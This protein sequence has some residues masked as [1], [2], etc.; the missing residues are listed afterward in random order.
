MV[1]YQLALK[2]LSLSGY[3]VVRFI[4]L[5]GI[6]DGSQEI[7]SSISQQK[8]RHE[9]NTSKNALEALYKGDIQSFKDELKKTEA[10]CIQAT[11][12]LTAIAAEYPNRALLLPV[13][14]VLGSIFAV[15]GETTLLTK[16]ADGL[17]VYQPTQ[18]FILAATVVIAAS[19]IVEIY[20]RLIFERTGSPN[21]SSKQTKYLG[22]AANAFL[23]LDIAFLVFFGWLRSLEILK[24]NSEEWGQ[25]F[26]DNPFVTTGCC[27]LITIILPVF[28]GCAFGS[29][30]ERLNHFFRSWK[31]ERKVTRLT[32][33]IDQLNHQTLAFEKESEH[34]QAIVEEHTLKHIQN[35]NNW[36]QRGEVL[37]DLNPYFWLKL[38]KCFAVCLL[39][40][41]A[42][43][44]SDPVI[45]SYLV[46]D[47]LR[48]L[49]YAGLTIGLTALFVYFELDPMA[50][51]N[52]SLK[53]HY[54]NQKSL[55]S[56]V[57]K[58]EPFTIFNER[59]NFNVY[60]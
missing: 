14:G 42:F 12:E 38:F 28:V 6:W 4:W 51:K 20:R 8:I 27:I 29:S 46:S 49:V 56:R 37:F 16:L 47:G 48:Y 26:Q 31:A 19:G 35:Y 17:G 1:K 7:D 53:N 22:L 40:L 54:Q 11:Q 36:Y 10:S 23:A 45:A 39:I 33:Q 9:F 3:S 52:I 21:S 44:I 58:V 34:L 25:V 2:K 43:L 32:C 13:L 18:Q 60:K 59:R 57:S 50:E 24:Q 55:K 5:H 15:L 41:M 30:L